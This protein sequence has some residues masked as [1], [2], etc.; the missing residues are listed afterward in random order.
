MFLSSL[1]TKRLN[2]RSRYIE[3]SLLQRTNTCFPSDVDVKEEG[4]FMAAIDLSMATR[5]NFKIDPVKGCPDY[6]PDIYR[7]LNEIFKK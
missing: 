3:L 2:L 4:Y 6:R 5:R 1:V 7:K